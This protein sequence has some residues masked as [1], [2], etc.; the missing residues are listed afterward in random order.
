MRPSLA[1]LEQHPA[2][3]NSLLH[4]WLLLSDGPRAVLAVGR[5]TPNTA[6]NE[7]LRVESWMKVPGAPF[8]L[9]L[10][11]IL[12]QALSAAHNYEQMSRQCNAA[13]AQ[14]GLKRSD[15]P[16]VAYSELTKGY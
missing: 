8:I 12:S 2:A 11:S 10:L 1:S 7:P 4:R 3:G 14:R 16:R 5:S 6:S 9:E 13:L 15:L